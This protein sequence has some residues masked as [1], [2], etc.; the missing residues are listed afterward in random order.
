M[1]AGQ[2]PGR[3]LEVTHLLLEI[4]HALT[5]CDYYLCYYQEIKIFGLISIC[6]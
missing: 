1:I 3:P 2:V 5:C 4:F 6:K